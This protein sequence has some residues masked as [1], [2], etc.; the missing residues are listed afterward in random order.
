[1][2]DDTRKE[3]KVLFYTT[4]RTGEDMWNRW[5]E[6]SRD[7]LTMLMNVSCRVCCATASAT[8]IVGVLVAARVA[9]RGMAWHGTGLRV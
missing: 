5:P 4:R 3:E 9:A 8:C 7:V 1:M 6:E 2:Q